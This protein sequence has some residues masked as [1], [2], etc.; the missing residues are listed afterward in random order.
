M[1]HQLKNE[2]YNEEYED[3]AIMFATI[4]NLDINYDDSVENEKNM[5]NVLNEI[6]CDFDE[7]LL[8]ND[9]SLKIE[10]IKVAGWTY[11]AACGLDVGRSE[12]CS[13]M[14]IRNMSSLNRASLMTN[15]RRSLN[16]PSKKNT[17]KR[18]QS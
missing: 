3:V 11:M 8:I 16:Q 6:I 14:G 4:T 1:N 12:S 5:L 15:G 17:N 10:K 13:S 9:E 18:E 7:Q 2:F